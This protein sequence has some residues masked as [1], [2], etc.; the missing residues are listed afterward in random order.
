MAAGAATVDPAAA[1]GTARQQAA[2]PVPQVWPLR[3]SQTSRSTF[4]LS[5]LCTFS[6]P[7]EQCGAL[8]ATRMSTSKVVGFG[9]SQT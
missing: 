9:G 2:A 1:L 8:L 5:C 7:N 6:P 3:L 4:W